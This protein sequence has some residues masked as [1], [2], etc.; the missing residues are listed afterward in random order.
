MDTEQV[1]T[2]FTYDMP[3]DSE[4]YLHQVSSTCRGTPTLP[5][6]YFLYLFILYTLIPPSGSLPSLGSSSPAL[7]LLPGGTGLGH[8]VCVR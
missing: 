6:P 7:C 5:P 4:T 2:A 3:E 8:H 1:N